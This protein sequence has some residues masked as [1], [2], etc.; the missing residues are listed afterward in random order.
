MSDIGDYALPVLVLL[1]IGHGLYKKIAVFEVFLQGAKEGVKTMFHLLPTLVGLITAVT[2]FQSSGV[3]DILTVTLQPLAT[4]LGLPCEVIPLALIH[5]VSSGGAT[6]VL[7]DIFT[8]FGPDS[9]LGKIASVMCGSGE[10]TFY[11][12][13]VYYGAVGVQNSRHTIPVALLADFLV[14]VLSGIGVRMLL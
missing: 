10:T 3:L 9:T 6:A 5:P 7:T 8:R 13:T 4:V 11:S 12:V 14:A 1:I 2:M